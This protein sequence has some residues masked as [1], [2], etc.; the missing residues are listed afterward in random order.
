MAST[1]T[2][3]GPWPEGLEQSY[4]AGRGETVRD[5]TLEGVSTRFDKTQNS[6]STDEQ[7]WGIPKDA[8]L[9]EEYSFDHMSQLMAIPMTHTKQ[10]LA[11]HF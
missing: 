6:T 2:T 11:D 1:M 10:I 7:R 4:L 9:V 3:C 8:L 5:L